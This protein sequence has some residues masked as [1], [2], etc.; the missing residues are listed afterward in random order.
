MRKKL[1]FLNILT[2]IS[3][4]NCTFYRKRIIININTL[5]MYMACNIVFL[6]RKQNPDKYTRPGYVFDGNR[7]GN[8]MAWKLY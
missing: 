6:Y 5:H 7:E 8:L 1:I 3:K 2:N 4:R